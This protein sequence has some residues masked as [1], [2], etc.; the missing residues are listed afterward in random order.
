MT[1]KVIKTESPDELLQVLADTVRAEVK[2][3]FERVMQLKKHAAGSVD[4]T[5]EYVEAMLGLQVY[6]H[7]LYQCA[8][9]EPHEG[10]HNHG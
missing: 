7:K 3:R 9:A 1:E 10:I 8:K 5:R 6:S 2:K 4:E